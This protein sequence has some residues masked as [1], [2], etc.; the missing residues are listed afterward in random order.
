MEL[1]EIGFQRTHVNNT[2]TKEKV[3]GSKKFYPKVNV[4]DIQYNDETD[5]DEYVIRVSAIYPQHAYRVVEACM[6]LPEY[7]EGIFD[8]GRVQGDNTCF[9]I[10]VNENNLE[11]FANSAAQKI[12]NEVIKISE[13]KKYRTPYGYD[14]EAL[15]RLGNRIANA[16]KNIASKADIE[17][18]EN[19]ISDS[20]VQILSNLNDPNVRNKMLMF[21][22]TAYGAKKLGWKLSPGNIMDI[23]SQKPDATFAAGANYWADY[24]RR[25][26]PNAQKL[27][28]T[29][30]TNTY[31]S[32]DDLDDAARRRGFNSHSDASNLTNNSKQ[33]N[34]SIYYDANMHKVGKKYFYKAIVYDVSDTEVINP[35]NGDKWS[36][37]IGLINNLHELLNNAAMQFQKQF[38]SDENK[39][40]E[41]NADNVF[42]DNVRKSLF[43]F[44]NKQG[45]TINDTGNDN[46]TLAKAIFDFALMRAPEENTLKEEN[47][48]ELAK[49]ITAAVTTQLE[50][51]NS[52]TSE[53]LSKRPVADKYIAAKAYNTVR[54]IISNIRMEIN[55][56]VN[57]IN[58][59]SP[60]EF[61]EMMKKV[62]V[63]FKKTHEAI[64]ESFF[65]FLERMD[66]SNKNLLL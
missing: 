43:K 5:E 6:K 65:K 44:F 26:K 30:P 31:V 9:N 42:M 16:A 66:N 38:S 28:I 54:E 63:R 27:V 45:V 51:P 41:D 29:K 8:I 57:G 10:F 21:Q 46:E 36:E 47:K 39:S 62:G 24:G 15:E 17:S 50:I 3:G 37:E 25:I 1:N 55:E 49:F 2:A 56:S 34:Q 13:N 48:V 7:S 33:V 40:I 60:K 32:K 19:R 14:N 53:F 59:L 11:A 18:A 61:I 4:A 52:I 64:H 12:A 22:T 35:E 23:L 20:W 58:I